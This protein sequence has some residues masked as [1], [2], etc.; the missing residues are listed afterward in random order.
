MAADEGK[1]G[2][3]ESE[4]VE[5]ESTSARGRLWLALLV[6]LFEYKFSLEVAL[7]RGAGV[8]FTVPLS[9]DERSVD[10]QGVSMLIILERSERVAKRRPNKMC[11]Y[12]IFP[13]NDAGSVPDPSL[14][15]S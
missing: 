7:Q 14:R 8:S 10:Q 11:A 13:L 9:C 12:I 1:L 4:S 2:W 15:D 6:L 5:S 3:E